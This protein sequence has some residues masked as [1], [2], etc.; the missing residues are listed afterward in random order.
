MEKA[1]KVSIFN[2]LGE[3]I[4]TRT[5]IQDFLSEISKLKEKE[6]TLDFN[7]VRFISRSCTDEYLKFIRTSK[8]KI[9]SVNQSQDLVMMIK[10][11]ENGLNAISIRGTKDNSKC[12]LCKN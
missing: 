3:R 4:F 11:V 10:A 5:T 6:I 12:V 2:K 9:K 1:R 8:K 7:K